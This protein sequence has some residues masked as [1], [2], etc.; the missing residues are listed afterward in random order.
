MIHRVMTD[1]V[2]S[3]CSCDFSTR[4][5]TKTSRYHVLH[6]VKHFD[7][8]D[9]LSSLIVVCDLINNPLTGQRPGVKEVLEEG[10]HHV[11]AVTCSME[12][13]S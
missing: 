10:C 7:L 9:K 8:E 1:L 5:K 12:A 11:Q 4:Q 13:K 2:T 6:Q 3:F